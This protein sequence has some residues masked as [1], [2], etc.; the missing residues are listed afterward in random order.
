MARYAITIVA[1]GAD[2]GRH[3]ARIVKREFRRPRP[4]MLAYVAL[5]ALAVATLAVVVLALQR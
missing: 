3:Y 4:E 1:M 5:A 2:A